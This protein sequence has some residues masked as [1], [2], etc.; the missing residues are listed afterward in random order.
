MKP[1][2]VSFGHGLVPKIFWVRFSGQGVRL[3]RA[4]KVLQNYWDLS[5]PAPSHR[6]DEKPEQ[7]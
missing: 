6:R 7:P 2:I 3:E 4:G 5:A 1:V